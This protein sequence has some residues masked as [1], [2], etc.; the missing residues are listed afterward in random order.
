[1]RKHR[2]EPLL[3]KVLFLFT[4]VM[5]QSRKFKGIWITKDIWE[6]HELS[7]TDRCLLAEIDSL[8]NDPKLR[9]HASNKYFAEFF[10]VSEA[11]IKR[12]IAKLKKLGLIDF[13][14]KKTQNGTLRNVWLIGTDQNELSTGQNDPS[15]RVKM[16]LP[17]GSKRPTNNIDINN[18][19]NSIED[20]QG[21][22]FQNSLN[23]WPTFDDFWQLYDYKKGKKAAEKKWSKLKQ[24]DKEAIMEHVPV[25]VQSTPDVQYRKHPATYLNQEA[26]HDVVNLQSPR[27]QENDFYN[28]ILNN[29]GFS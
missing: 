26:W 22:I 6:C 23:L 18:T 20:N 28:Q 21:E 11:T 2:I 24:K 9:C 15:P 14:H 12:S 5:K 3:V 29:G 25:Y 16:T 27:Q 1:M 17:H 4:P 8:D 7:P 13:K 10:G 19:V